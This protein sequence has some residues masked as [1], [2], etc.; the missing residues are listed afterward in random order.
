YTEPGELIGH[1]VEGVVMLRSKAQE[2]MRKTGQRLPRGACMVLE[3]I[4]I[5]HHGVPEFGAAKV[6]ATP[7]ALLVSILDNLDAKPVVPLRAARPARPPGA[8]TLSLGGNFTERHWGL[9]TKL[10]RPDP[11]AD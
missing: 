5:S 8:P 1:C 6:P 10:Y 3:H 7:E 2:V 9:D 4:V 11:L